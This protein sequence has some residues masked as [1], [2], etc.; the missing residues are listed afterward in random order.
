MLTTILRFLLTR[1]FKPFVFS[2]R[3]DYK[4]DIDVKNLGFYFHIPFCRKICDF[5]PYYKVR[6]KRELLEDFNSALLAE[7]ELIAGLSGTRKEIT[8]VY[9]GGGSPALMVEYFPELMEKVNRFFN[10]RGPAGIELHLGDVGK[11]LLQKIK[12]CGFDM[13]SIGIQSFQEKCLRTLGRKERIDGARRIELAA[14]AGFM[15]VDVDLIFGIHGQTP[16]DMVNDFRTA[17]ESGATQISTYPFIDFSYA[18]QKEKPL[19]KRN[20]KEMLKSILRISAKMGYERSSIW[21]Y[22]KRKT[23]KYSSV[24]RDNFVGF[25]PSAATLLKDIFKVNTFSVK[26]YIK[27]LQRNEIPTALSLKF[28]ERRRA[29]YWLFWSVYN[30]DISSDKFRELFGKELNDLFRVELT[31]GT[32]LN[33]FRK[34]G[35]DYRLTEKGAYLFHLVEQAYTHQYIDK[36]WATALKNPWPKKIVLY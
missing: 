36:T 12:T 7:M 23:L 5:C 14:E 35:S 17:A 21:T 32:G 16:E 18:K 29:L 20:Q 9:F 33:Y 26:E 25:G 15:V 34:C 22:C 24:T 31:M 6:Y 10:F 8:S 11:K 4:L 19:G 3:K 13:V 28:D 1:S 2:D 30:L 27:S